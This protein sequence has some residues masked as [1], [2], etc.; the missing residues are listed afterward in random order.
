MD[1][2]ARWVWICIKRAALM[3]DAERG[4]CGTENRMQT[5][6]AAK[7]VVGFLAVVGMLAL[8][9]PGVRVAR[10]GDGDAALPKLSRSAVSSSSESG[11]CK[12][13]GE[14]DT[15]ATRS[16]FS[17]K[18]AER[19][20]AEMQSSD[21]KPVVLNGRGY[22]YKISRDPERELRMVESEAAR[23]QE[24]APAGP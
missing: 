24:Q 15:R 13:G 2:G 6:S 5:G 1:F 17:A 4:R 14:T 20:R 3:T 16:D 12:V 18:I 23:Q 22:N 7:I 10:A 8:S 21:E 9:S 11:S 19:L